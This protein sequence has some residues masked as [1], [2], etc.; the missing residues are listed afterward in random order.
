MPEA[1]VPELRRLRLRRTEAPGLGRDQSRRRAR[2]TEASTSRRARTAASGGANPSPSAGPAGSTPAVAVMAFGFREHLRARLPLR[3]LRRRRALA[4]P[5]AAARV[6]GAALHR[7]SLSSTPG[8]QR[9]VAHGR[10]LG[11]AEADGSA[12]TVVRIPRV[13]A[14]IAVAVAGRPNDAFVASGVC[15]YESFE[16]DRSRDDLRRCLESPSG[17]SS[18]R[19][20]PSPGTGSSESPTGPYRRSS[21]ARRSASCVF[22]VATDSVPANRAGSVPVG[23]VRSSFA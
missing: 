14:S 13:P 4:L 6:R 20:A 2:E 1:D 10:P 5:A 7:A 8:P 18:T 11:R 9:T 3:R 19:P 22:A 16:N 12:V 15:P 23:R 17:F 21:T